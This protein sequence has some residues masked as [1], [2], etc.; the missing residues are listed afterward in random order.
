MSAVLVAIL[1][2]LSL[3]IIFG[4]ILGYAAV[5]FKVE[6]NPIVDQIDDILP[7]TQCGQCGYPGCRPY[8]EAIANG[9]AIN[10]CPPGG[11][12]TIEALADLLDVEAVA[13][14]A[15]H[16]EESVK[17][18]A[19]IREDECIGCT[20]CIQACP[21]DAILG[22]AKQ[23]H[24]V[25]VSECTGCD[26]CVEPCPV[27]CIDMLPIETT[28]NNWKWTPPVPGIE[29]IATDT[30]YSSD[31]LSSEQALNK[32]ALNKQASSKEKAVS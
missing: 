3:A 29:L 21:V 27:D 22:A 5:Q 31:P 1:V 12:T 24:T 20:K 7:Q 13:L 9:E 32:Q 30:G 14:D 19:Y 10:K 23:M 25:I 26:L 17:T 16:G 15:E 11:Q 6:G 4:L 2:L 28:L 18:V 8:A